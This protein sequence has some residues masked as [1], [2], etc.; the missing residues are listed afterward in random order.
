VR[1]G[2]IL[3]LDVSAQPSSLVTYAALAGLLTAFGTSR[4]K[5][6]LPAA[7]AF[8]GAGVTLHLLSL[9]VHHFG[10]ALAARSAG[11]PMTGV[12]LF[13]PI[14]SSVY[15]DEP[16]LPVGTHL[17][18]ALGGPVSSFLFSCLILLIRPLARSSRV[19]QVLWW[20]LFF[21][22]VFDFALGSLLPLE[23]TDGG[24]IRRNCRVSGRRDGDSRCT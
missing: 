16:P 13:G 23:F 1:L 17:R 19:G 6:R 2:R 10:H 15:P 12:R 5:L 11:Y 7:V 21:D 3:G 4:L 20:Y 24:T 9:L 22:N 8:A 14:A 18:R